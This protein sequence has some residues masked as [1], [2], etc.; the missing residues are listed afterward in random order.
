M[1][2]T[3]YADETGLARPSVASVAELAGIDPGTARRRLGELQTVG[4]IAAAS[5]RSRGGAPTVWRLRQPAPPARVEPVDNSTEPAQATRVT[6]AG[7]AGQPAQWARQPAQTQGFNPRQPREEE[8]KRIEEGAYAC[9]QPGDL[10][11][12]M[13]P[14]E[15]RQRVDALRAALEAE[16]PPR[17]PYE[18]EP[19]PHL[20][21]PAITDPDEIPARVAALRDARRGHRDGLRPSLTNGS[22]PQVPDSDIRVCPRGDPS[23]DDGW[24]S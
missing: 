3:L 9:P 1:A 15:A 5:G 14:D 16:P 22:R 11:P 19:A 2:L 20:A 17:E 13:T 7:H 24:I 4:A 18:P 6:R 23:G 8:M 10:P 21:D 12:P